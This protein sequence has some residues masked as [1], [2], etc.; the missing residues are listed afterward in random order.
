MGIFITKIL[1]CLEIC[2]KFMN[3]LIGLLIM[4]SHGRFPSLLTYTG[5]ATAEDIS[6]SSFLSKH[7]RQQ[8]NKRHKL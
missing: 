3:I 8:S 6:D 2:L 1:E 7:W 5:I 4:I